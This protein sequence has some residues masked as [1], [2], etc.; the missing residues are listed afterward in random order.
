MKCVVID[1]HA[2]ARAILHQLLKLGG[3][4]R[5]RHHSIA[6]FVMPD[7]LIRDAAWHETKL[8]VAPN[9]LPAFKQ[10]AGDSFLRHRNTL[11]QTAATARQRS[12]IKATLPVLTTC[13]NA[14]EVS[15]AQ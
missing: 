15:N 8:A 2:D 4:A 10:F 13:R 6:R 7:V 3:L 12:A 1:Q 11:M 5:R 9:A 14:G